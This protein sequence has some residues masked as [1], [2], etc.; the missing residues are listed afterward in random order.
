MLAVFFTS[1]KLLTLVHRF[2]FLLKYLV[3]STLDSLQLGGKSTSRVTKSGT[4][5][6]IAFSKDR[7]L[8]LC[9][10]LESFLSRVTG[11][12]RIEVVYQSS[13]QRVAVA[14]REVMAS[15]SMCPNIGFIKQHTSFRDSVL[16]V[17]HRSTEEFL[18]FLVDD[19][20]FIRDLAVTDTLAYCGSKKIFSLRLAP[21]IQYCYVKNAQMEVPKLAQVGNMVFRWKWKYGCLDWSYALSL[22]SHIFKY[23]DLAPCIRICSFNSP[24]T[25]ESALQSFA[26]L[27]RSWDGLCAK[28][29]ITVNRPENIVQSDFKNRNEKGNV[30]FLLEQWERGYKYDLKGLSGH[31]NRSVHESIPLCLILR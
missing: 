30:Q 14:Y 17:L 12:A 22:D 8:Q 1:E 13:S 7:P 21:H 31:I 29:S 27:V 16:D 23:S 11:P 15:F 6:F 18:S 3:F 20:V 10:L 24:N 19:Q 4:L 9:L 5:L 28:Y 26:V 25:L 2:A